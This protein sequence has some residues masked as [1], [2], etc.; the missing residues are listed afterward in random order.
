MEQ[1]PVI[2]ERHTSKGNIKIFFPYF[3][4]DPNFYTSNISAEIRRCAVLWLTWNFGQL[5]ENVSKKKG[6]NNDD[7]LAKLQASPNF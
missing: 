7:L 5:T 3:L 6:V 4:N 1:E 2:E